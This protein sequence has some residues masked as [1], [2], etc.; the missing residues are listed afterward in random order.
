MNYFENYDPVFR[1]LGGGNPAEKV[2]E[3][4][5]SMVEDKTFKVEI[6][7]TSNTVGVKDESQ[8]EK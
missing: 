5:Q 7:S 1:R 3:T 6:V 2:T 8:A 4:P